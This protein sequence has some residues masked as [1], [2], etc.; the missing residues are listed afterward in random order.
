M[1]CAWKFEKLLCINKK[2]CFP[3]HTILKTYEMPTKESPLIFSEKGVVVS[4]DLSI[5]PDY[6]TGSHITSKKYQVK[7]IIFG[8]S[9]NKK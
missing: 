8:T 6:D 5:F 3:K 1:L 7:T 4:S 9:N 2:Q